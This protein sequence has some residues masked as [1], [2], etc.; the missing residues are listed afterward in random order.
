MAS[1]SMTGEPRYM[2]AQTRELDLSEY[3]K[4]VFGMFAGSREQLRLRFDRSL[5]G[6]VIDRFGR[7]TP[8]VPDGPDKFICTLEVAVS[9]NFFGWL[10]SFG[11]RAELL[12]P[13]SVRE[14]FVA[15]CREAEAA[16]S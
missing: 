15:L 12:S 4:N 6:V 7:G 10:A 2:D 9:P 16:N 3:G 8:C 11:A 14:A 5:T 13:A 1:I